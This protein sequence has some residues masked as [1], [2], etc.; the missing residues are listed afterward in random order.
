MN[1]HE[2]KGYSHSGFHCVPQARV[3][4][5]NNYR[6]DARTTSLFG[7]ITKCRILYSF[8]HFVPYFKMLLIL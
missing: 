7:I 6:K 5:L 4:A 8:F 1:I 3:S 2:G